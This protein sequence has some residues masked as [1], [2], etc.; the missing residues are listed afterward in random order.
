MRRSLF[1]LFSVRSVLASLFIPPT[2]GLRRTVGPPNNAHFT[3]AIKA[4]NGSDPKEFEFGV[5]SLL[6]SCIYEK[7]DEALKA[8][9]SSGTNIASLLP[10]ILVLIGRLSHCS[11]P[12]RS[13][14]W[15]TCCTLE[16]E[17]PFPLRTPL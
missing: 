12:Y 9:L 8:S 16:R 3:S 1:G 6:I 2:L 15:A 7:L 17:N 14:A 13:F 10:T 4:C 5:C 11:V